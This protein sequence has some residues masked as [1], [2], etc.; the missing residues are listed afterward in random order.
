MANLEP[1]EYISLGGGPP[2]A[3]PMKP[4]YEDESVT[5]FNADCRELLPELK[6]DL[7]LT[8]PPF[9]LPAAVG[10]SRKRWPRSIGET[11]V[12]E[13]YFRDVFADVV[14]TI[15]RTGAAYVFSDSTSYA[16]FL[17]LLYPL[18]DRTQCI[19]W[20]KG[21]GGLGNGWRHSHVAAKI[22]CICCFSISTVTKQFV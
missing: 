19:V 5:I 4:Y 13:G 14:G 17:S 10:T 3:F 20:D 6:A 16:V 15:P 2:Q 9:Y 18:F 11:A 21:V 1:I 22:G 8:D 7:V 12:M